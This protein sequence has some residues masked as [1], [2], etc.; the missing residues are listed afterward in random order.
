[1]AYA[2]VETVMLNGEMD[3]RASVTQESASADSTAPALSTQPTMMGTIAGRVGGPALQ[4]RIARRAATRASGAGD[5]KST[6]GEVQ[7]EGDVDKKGA[8]GGDDQAKEGGKGGEHHDEESGDQDKKTAPTV[9]TPPTVTFSKTTIRKDTTPTGMPD[10]IAPRQGFSL[11][12]NVSGQQKGGAPVT[13]EVDGSGTGAG[14][15][16]VNGKASLNVK[17]STSLTLKGTVQTSPGSGG[18]LAL[19]AKQGTTEL[20][21]TDPFTVSAIPK[22][23]KDTFVRLLTGD[24]RGFVVQDDWESDSGKFSDLDEA[25]I[26]ELVQVTS[27]SGSFS[28]NPSNTSSYLPAN[29]KTKDTHSSATAGLTGPGTRDASQTC[30]F[31]DKRT[32]ASDIPMKRSGYSLERV[33]KAAKG[34]KLKFTLTKKGAAVTANGVS[35]EAGSGYISKTQ[36][37]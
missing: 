31:R 15:V 8:K 11:K 6:G 35:S 12:V 24:Q 25:E 30:M 13:V 23:Y 28:G 2:N 34:G 20:A 19:V 17:S 10:R 32:G 7:G 5:A 4:R 3:R 9:V 37:V 1:M 22:N 16:Q 18:G 21:R 27:S 26:S 29:S 36:D 14:T 33:V